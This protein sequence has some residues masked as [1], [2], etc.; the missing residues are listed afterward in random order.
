MAIKNG[1]ELKPENLSQESQK[2]MQDAQ[3]EGRRA[4]GLERRPGEGG[5]SGSSLDKNTALGYNNG[6][7]KKTIDSE[8]ESD[9]QNERSTGPFD[10]KGLADGENYNDLSDYG[11][12][13]DARRPDYDELSKDDDHDYGYDNSESGGGGADGYKP[14]PDK[15]GYQ[16]NGLYEKNGGTIVS[17]FQSI[18]ESW[19]YNNK[20]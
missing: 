11:H 4:V 3:R 9:R 6:P 1:E 17:S 2:A 16:Y 20:G 15:D 5:H 7:S 8:T 12:G 10:R 14:G 18:F 13:G 19:L